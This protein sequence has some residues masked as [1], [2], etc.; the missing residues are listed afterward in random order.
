MYSLA[1]RIKEKNLKLKNKTKKV[2]IR[3]RNSSW[4]ELGIVIG[5][6]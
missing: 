6:N 2:C 3:I 4:I 1:F 5:L